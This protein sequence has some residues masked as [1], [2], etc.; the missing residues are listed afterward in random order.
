[1]GQC[2]FHYIFI[3][4]EKLSECLWTNILCIFDFISKYIFIIKR[5][6]EDY[7]I[8][9]TFGYKCVHS[10]NYI[11]H[12]YFKASLKGYGQKIYTKSVIIY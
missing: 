11:L 3:S 1:M 8:E 12:V 4:I 5:Y 6:I 2:A 7:N 10:F 9:D